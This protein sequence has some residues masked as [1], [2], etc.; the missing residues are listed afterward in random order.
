MEGDNVRF[1]SQAGAETKFWGWFKKVGNAISSGVKAIGKAVVKVGKTIVK[2]AK[3]VAKVVVDA[4]K[5]VAAV[6]KDFVQTV[7]GTKGEDDFGM[8]NDIKYLDSIFLC[9]EEVHVDG[10]HLV[11]NGTIFMRYALDMHLYFD[12]KMKQAHSATDKKSSPFEERF[13]IERDETEDVNG[14]FVVGFSFEVSVHKN[15]GAMSPDTMEKIYDEGIG[16][17]TPTNWQQQQ[18]GVW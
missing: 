12:P 2:V 16:L 17:V 3:K 18:Q 15:D 9:S 11:Y 10:Q 4:A 5:T 1:R 8:G 14:R 7:A 6:V 13:N